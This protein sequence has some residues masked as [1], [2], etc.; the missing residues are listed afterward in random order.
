[1]AVVIGLGV[2]FVDFGVDG[3]GFVSSFN[4]ESFVG[5]Q[6]GEFFHLVVGEEVGIGVQF[7]GGRFNLSE[8]DVFGVVVSDNS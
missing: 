3:L 7:L 8:I 5:G 2:P 4:F 6:R 1:L